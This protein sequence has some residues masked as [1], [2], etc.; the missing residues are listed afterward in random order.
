MV[1]LYEQLPLAVQLR[2]DATLSNFYPADNGLLLRSLHQQLDSLLEGS[3]ERYLYL[4]GPSACGK[5]HLLQAACHRI[6]CLG[7]ASAYLPLQE[8]QHYQPDELFEGLEQLS[9]V[10]LDDIDCVLDKPDWQLSL[11]NLFNRLHDHRVGLLITAKRAVREMD[12]LLADLASRL[13]WGAVFQIKTLTDQ[14]RV[15]VVQLRAENRGLKLSDEVAQFIY[16]RCQRD[17]KTLLAVLGTL[18]K[19][20]LKQQRR[21][22]VPFVKTIMGW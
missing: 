7:L 17:T 19:A 8:L 18:D 20:S 2:D 10:C 3:G 21:L 15:A 16:H 1:F 4:Y 22:T 14:Q 9:L 13:S 12:V 11:F 5:S 6:D